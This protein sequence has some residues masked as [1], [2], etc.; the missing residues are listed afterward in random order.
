[1]YNPL[2]VVNNYSHRTYRNI[3]SLI[4][5]L[6][7]TNNNEEEVIIEEQSWTNYML[8]NFSFLVATSGNVMAQ[9]IVSTT[10]A[11]TPW[12]FI[13]IVNSMK[14]SIGMITLEVMFEGG[15][16][17]AINRLKKF[18]TSKWKREETDINGK[19]E[20]LKVFLVLTPL[21]YFNV[22]LDKASNNCFT[23]FLSAEILKSTTINLLTSLVS[24]F[25]YAEMIL[26][27]AEGI[28]IGWKNF[29]NWRNKTANS[30]ITPL[31]INNSENI[32]AKLAKKSFFSK[33]NIRILSLFFPTAVLTTWISESFISDQSLTISDFLIEMPN[34]ILGISIFLISSLLNYMVNGEKIPFLNIKKIK[35]YIKRYINFENNNNY[36]QQT[37]ISTVVVAANSIDIEN[38]NTVIVDIHPVPN[39][40]VDDHLVSNEIDIINY[41]S[42][43][44]LSSVIS[45][46]SSNDEVFYDAI[47]IVS[48]EHE[49]YFDASSQHL[50]PVDISIEIGSINNCDSNEEITTI[51][52]NRVSSSK[53][54]KFL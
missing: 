12:N 1:M 5:N 6:I 17:N 19:K 51:L 46:Q 40:S 24:M 30:E 28:K 25:L 29:Q 45:N 32:T 22:L 16:F 10:I 47:S 2:H 21:D 43:N 4:L 39:S 36:L 27:V 8:K 54:E 50:M 53:V 20:L 33:K 3:T 26:T 14:Y 7:S 52:D 18:I 49:T 11:K 34:V 31:L 48:E 23:T 37:P 41:N 15:V 9:M 35:C 44:D 13:N 38:N 42:K